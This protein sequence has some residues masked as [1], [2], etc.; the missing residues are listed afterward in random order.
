[1]LRAALKETKMPLSKFQMTTTLLLLCVSVT[2]AE[3][4]H[5][6]EWSVFQF[7]DA[8][9]GGC[10][11]ALKN[12]AVITR[13]VELAA[14]VA[15]FLPGLYIVYWWIASKSENRDERF[16]ILRELAHCSLSVG[17]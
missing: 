11:A 3:I 16:Q 4:Y 1:M 10:G 15:V 14:H 13:A 9:S 6:I 2:F 7:G 5:A 12:Y 17:R 8:R